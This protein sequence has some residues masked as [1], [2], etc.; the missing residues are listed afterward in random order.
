MRRLKKNKKV[1]GFIFALVATLSFATFFAGPA[2][3]QL[4]GASSGE[5]CNKLD[6][7]NCNDVTLNELI[8]KVINWILAIVLAIDVLFIIIG[9]FL[10]ITAAGNEDRA[11][12]GRTTVIN[13]V[14]G[15]VIIIMAYVIAQVVSSF[16]A[17]EQTGI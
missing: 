2:M 6:G 1:I 16:F 8:I 7:I 9:G 11:K 10:Y 15:L 12:K 5:L 3:A 4:P 14:I 13:A 17:E